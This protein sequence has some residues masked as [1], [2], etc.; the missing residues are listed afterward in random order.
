MNEYVRVTGDTKYHKDVAGHMIN[1]LIGWWQTPANHIGYNPITKTMSNDVIGIND[2]SNG[3]GYWTM[4]RQDNYGSYNK[5]TGT[6]PW[7]AGSI[8]GNAILFYEQDKR[9]NAVGQAAGISHATLK[10][11]L[12]QSMNY[13]VKHGYD[14]DKKWFAYSEVIRH[15]SGG[16]NHL[17]YPLA[18]LNRLHNTELAAGKI[19]HPEWYDTSS[20][21]GRIA[22]ERYDE[23]NATNAVANSTSGGFYGY[24]I[25]YPMDFFKLMSE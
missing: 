12:F 6:N 13:V 21:W 7:M 19:A 8:L 4:R 18:Y 17:V 11:M 9:L 22:Q 5:A 23:L 14:A 20:L 16:S 1:Y 2:A 3:T 15:Y 25:V 24:E 10:D